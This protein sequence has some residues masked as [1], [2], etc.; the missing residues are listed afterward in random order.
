MEQELPFSPESRFTVRERH[1]KGV[2]H[3]I[4]NNPIVPCR[5]H[6]PLSRRFSDKR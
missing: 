4:V 1:A 3:A 2:G 5:R 6:V